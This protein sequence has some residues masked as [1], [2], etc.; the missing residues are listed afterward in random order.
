M[1][2]TLTDYSLIARDIQRSI[3]QVRSDPIVARETEY[4]LKNIGNVKTIDDFV[5]DRRLFQYAMKAHGLEDMTYAKAFMV[6]VL[7][8]G[9]DDSDAFAN[10]LADK[11][12]LEFAKTFDFNRYTTAATT[13]TRA[14]QGVVDR[15]LRQ[16]LEENAGSSNEGVRL[17]LYFQRKAPDLQSVTEILADKAMAQVVR[18]AFGLPASFAAADLDH[19]I[20]MYKEKIDVADF[21]DPDKLTKFI[22]RFAAM[23]DMSNGSSGTAA[24]TAGLLFGGTQ[25][26]GLSA[27]LMIA[28]QKYKP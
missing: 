17:A 21:A 10:K 14:Q 16:T 5:N 9:R 2:G 19:Q 23:W 15:Y 25:S 7:K 20:Q 12:Y 6:K 8:E 18:V 4:Y 26:F 27:D 13:F 3:T 1:V 22:G 28:I 11:R 24:A